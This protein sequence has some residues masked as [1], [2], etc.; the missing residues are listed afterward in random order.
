[1]VFTMEKRLY[2]FNSS[3]FPWGAIFAVC[4]IVAFEG[5]NV[6]MGERLETKNPSVAAGEYFFEERLDEIG[7]L[8]ASGEEP[9]DILILGDCFLCWGVMPPII[10][11]E[12][13]LSCY[14]MSAY[15]FQSSIG[16]YAILSNYL[17]H[18]AS[19]PKY[20][21]LG[22]TIAS[23]G[24]TRRQTQNQNWDSLR[25]GNIALFVREFG[26]NQLSKAL[27]QALP[28]S[29]HR[30][31]FCHIVRPGFLRT[32]RKWDRLRLQFNEDLA[33]NKGYYAPWSFRVSGSEHWSDARAVFEVDPF[34]E[35]YLKKV[36]DLAQKNDI[37]VLFLKATGP[38]DWY[39]TH[40]LL[41]NLSKLD[42]YIE[43]L[44]TGHPLGVVDFQE[45]LDDCEIYADVH[46]G[47]TH[48]N[49]NGASEMSV[50][51]AERIKSQGL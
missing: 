24:R 41:G 30:Y 9:F 18:C 36:L 46:A 19:P 14:N 23:F 35:K 10:E 17:R 13:G 29:R 21:V 7:R 38:A 42:D 15:I 47:W 32:K 31:F 4:M 33:A 39:S 25:R 48:L 1:M 37:R 22:Y 12:T 5:V 20:I 16:T 45:E 51:L 40:C 49:K 34:F 26:L 6:L 2:T 50:L 43:N 8:A 28:S 11:N 27:G 44:G 3:M